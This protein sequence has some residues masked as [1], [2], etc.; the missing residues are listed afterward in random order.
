MARQLHRTK[1]A[2][3]P[4]ALSKM[5]WFAQILRARAPRA[6]LAAQRLP[7]S[8]NRVVEV[9]KVPG[10][11]TSLGAANASSLLFLFFSCVFC[12]GAPSWSSVVTFSVGL[13]P[14]YVNRAFRFASR[15]S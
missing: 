15:L 9:G 13:V 6:Q 14:R 7:R 2:F 8:T 10:E 4:S 1:P 12:A 5:Q 11:G 3:V